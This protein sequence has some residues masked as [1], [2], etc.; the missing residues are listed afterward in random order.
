MR[1]SIQAENFGVRL[2]PVQLE[3]AA[4][5]VWLRN[6]GHVKGKVGDSASDV[7]MQRAWLDAYFRRQGDY[8]FIIETLGGIPVGTHSVYDVLAG[9]GELGRWIIRPGIQAAVPSHMVAFAIAF[10]QLGLKALRNVT[11]A[12]NLPVLSISRRFG[13]EEVRFDRGGRVIA[14]K[15]VDMV[16]FVLTAEKWARTRDKLVPM[17]RVAEGLVRQWEQGQLAA[18]PAVTQAWSQPELS[19][20]V[21]C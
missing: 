7:P 19:E 5:I 15:P 14:G 2:R 12:S 21:R 1:H 18:I 10:E 17:S 3:D 8:Y 16:H 20:G 9:S 4:F 6:L 11:V 13:F